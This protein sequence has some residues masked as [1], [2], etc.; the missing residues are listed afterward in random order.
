ME[1]EMCW[2]DDEPYPYEPE[3]DNPEC[4]GCGARDVSIYN[5]LTGE[6]WCCRACREKRGC[7]CLELEV[8]R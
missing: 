2:Y 8:A 7:D 6:S 1:H 5:T 4:Y 3:P